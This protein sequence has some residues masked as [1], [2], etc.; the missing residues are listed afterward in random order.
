VSR[1]IS[2]RDFDW[3]LL[4]FVLL[5]CGFGVMEIYSA[6]LNTNLAG[7]HLHVSQIYWVTA[8]VGLMFVMSLVNYQVLLENVHWLYL[9][10]IGSLLGVM[11][12]G[13]KY[14]GAKRWIRMPGGVHFQ[15]S[16]WVKLVLILA[17]A[18]YFADFRQREL[19]LK[20]LAK[21][22]LVCGIP[23]LLV[24]KQ[25]D[26]G[27]S[28]TY[29]PIAVVALFLGGMKG[30]HAAA[31]VLL[32]ALAAPLGWKH[33]KPYQKQRLSS[34]IHPEA[35]SQGAGYQSEQAL[36]AVGQGGLTGRGFA[37]GSQTQGSFIPEPHNDFI[38]AAWSEEHGF[39]G[40]MTVLLLYFIVLMRLIHNAQTAP[41]RAGAFV[42]M[43]VVAVLTFHILINVGMV[44][45][46]MPVTGIPLPLMSYGGSSVLFTFLALGIVNNIRMRRFVN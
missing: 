42:V 38:F 29:I 39:V 1:Y 15:P 13:T 46:F 2:F 40:A 30:K 19:N 7:K 23:F 16:E 8:G 43:G 17:M 28:L 5:I 12:F 36:I 11:I 9:A 10:A 37:R 35:D 26:L 41:D 25:P 44:V 22:S 18:K 24:F 32:V 27:T 31:I 33:M 4:A 21:A 3:V 34:F 14:L 6:T 45:G 20:E